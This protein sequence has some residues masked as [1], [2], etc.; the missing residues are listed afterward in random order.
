MY[1]NGLILHA[2]YKSNCIYDVSNSAKS[3]INKDNGD[4]VAM[5][6]VVKPIEIIL[7]QKWTYGAQH[8]AQ[9]K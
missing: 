6:L 3:L 7:L 8:E 1:E 4:M 5:R 9:Y 2:I